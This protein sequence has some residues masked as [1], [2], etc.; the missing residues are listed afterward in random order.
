MKYEANWQELPMRMEFRFKKK[1]AYMYSYMKVR[2]N[3]E[4][5]GI[6]T[7]EARE[8]Y[9]KELVWRILNA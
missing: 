1:F 5:Y 6:N 2:I 9:N 8:A 7:D 4:I 3:G